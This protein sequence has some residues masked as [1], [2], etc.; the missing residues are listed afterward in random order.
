[1]DIRQQKR[2]TDW[3]VTVA[4]LPFQDQGEKKKKLFHWK[5]Q[6]SLK[7]IKRTDAKL[8]FLIPTI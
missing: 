6:G 7:Q 3:L 4:L 5:Y 1:M 2:E 8:N